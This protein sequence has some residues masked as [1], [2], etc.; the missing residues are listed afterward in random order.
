M[1]G[2]G[3]LLAGGNGIDGKLRPGAAVAAYKHVWL[4]GLPCKGICLGGLSAAKL[5]GAALQQIAPADLLAD[6][7]QYPVGIHGD[8]VGIVVSRVK[9]VI[10]IKYGDTPAESDG[11]D[12]AVFYH[13]FFWA[14]AVVDGDA[15]CF[16]LLDLLV[17]GGHLFAALQAIHSDGFRLFPDGGPGHVDGNIAAADHQHFAV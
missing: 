10:V 11:F 1:N 8:G 15:L 9:A 2:D 17:Q 4:S 14:P 3:T 5:Y 13:Q 6:A 12:A 7:Q 16:R